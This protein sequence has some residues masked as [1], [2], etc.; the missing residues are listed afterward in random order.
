MAAALGGRR[1]GITRRD[2]VGEAQVAVVIGLAA[3]ICAQPQH[4]D[5]RLTQTRR[6]PVEKLQQDRIVSGRD[7]AAVERG[8][9]IDVGLHPWRVHSPPLELGG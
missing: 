9:R 6:E 3:V 1:D 2:G 5:H 7:D 8:V 4:V